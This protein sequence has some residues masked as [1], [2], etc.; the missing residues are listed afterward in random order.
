MGKI[1]KENIA[2]GTPRVLQ[3][4]RNKSKMVDGLFWTDLHQIWF[5]DTYTP[6]KGHWSPN[7]YFGKIQDGG[8]RNLGF[9][10]SAT[11]VAVKYLLKFDI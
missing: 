8:G 11:L 1:D 10:F 9:G 3:M 4:G 2:Q 6:Y 5:V 7:F